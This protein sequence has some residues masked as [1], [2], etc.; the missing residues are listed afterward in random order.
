MKPNVLPPQSNMGLFKK[1]KSVELQS[2]IDDLL[3]ENTNLKQECAG[4]KKTISA[5]VGVK[6]AYD[7][8]KNKLMKSHENEVSKL[9]QQIEL[10]KKSVAKKVNAELASIGIHQFVPEEISMDNLM[11][12]PE[13]LLEKF[14]S[15]P[16]SPEKHEFF[17]LHEKEISKA[18]K[19][20]N[21]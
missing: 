12:S 15:M 14:T 4:Y 8:E 19:I 7:E 20:K 21:Q 5:F 3:D 6:T 13:S 2:Q 10:E 1:D 17:K 9:K 16:E 11:L 18:M